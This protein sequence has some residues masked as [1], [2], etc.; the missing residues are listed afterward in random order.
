MKNNLLEKILDDRN[1]Y[2]AYKQV[3]KNKGTCGIDGI[4]VEELGIYMYEHKEKIKEQIRRLQYKPSPVRRVE[5][6]KENGK[7]RKLGIP[8]VIDR[9]IQQAIVQVLSPIFEKQFSKAGAHYQLSYFEKQAWQQETGGLS[10]LRKSN[11]GE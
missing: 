2:E 7:M 8:T 1:L 4:K 10:D 3:Y 9:L 11:Q 6:P 5:I